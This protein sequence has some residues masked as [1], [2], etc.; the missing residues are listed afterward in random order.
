MMMFNKWKSKGESNGG[1]AVVGSTRNITSQLQTNADGD[2]R[3]YRTHLIFAGKRDPEAPSGPSGAS[4][5]GSHFY[6]GHSSSHS[7][8]HSNHPFAQAQQIRQP[9]HEPAARRKGSRPPNLQ[10][11]EELYARGAN[12]QVS[13][14]GGGGSNAWGGGGGPGGAVPSSSSGGQPHMAYQGPPTYYNGHGGAPT[15]GVFEDPTG[16][17][18]MLEVVAGLSRDCF[19]IPL[20]CVDRFLPA[21]LTL[22]E[23]QSRSNNNS[24]SSSG[25][26]TPLNVLEVADP[27]LAV[28]VHLMTPLIPLSQPLDSPTNHPERVQRTLAMEL[29]ER[30]KL[31]RQASHGLL[32]ASMENSS[33][34]PLMALYV[35]PKLRTDATDF[36]ETARKNALDVF[37]PPTIGHCGDNFFHLCREVATIA[38]PPTEHN[39]GKKTKANATGYIVSIFRVFDGDDRE[40]LERNWLYWTGARTLYRHLPK[41]VGLR[42]I[43]LHKSALRGDKLYLLLCECSNFLENVNS[44][45]QLLPAL[46]A[47]LCGYTGIYRI[48][49]AF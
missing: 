47:R 44:A 12:K 46:R 24:S 38:R 21:G 45:A 29:I 48:A 43:T 3:G 1:G 14:G 22:P 6:G 16:K 32:L 39:G 10:V 36:L 37:D 11:E 33:D 7:L 2:H 19:I 15:T 34:F 18:G 8:S 25:A 17:P 5:S 13:F 27:Q 41:S 31:E 28:V 4:Q 20:A 35:V 23:L 30:A 42:R 40:K 26:G 49:H 9:P